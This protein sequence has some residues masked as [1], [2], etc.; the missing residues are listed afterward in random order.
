MS[1]KNRPGNFDCLAKLA[2]DEPF[3]VLRAQD[4]E[5]ADLVELWALRARAGGCPLDK[6]TE[7]MQVADEMRRWPRRKHPD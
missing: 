6:A 1:T 5:A 3:F 4:A 2:P 7:A